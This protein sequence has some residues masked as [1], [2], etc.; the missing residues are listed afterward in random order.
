MRSDIIANSTTLIAKYISEIYVVHSSGIVKFA[1]NFGEKRY[2]EA[3]LIGSFV[4]AIESFM[5]VTS[6]KLNNDDIKL[7]DIGTSGSRWFIKKSDEVLLLSIVP[8]NSKF[9]DMESGFD[10]IGEISSELITNF[11]YMHQEDLDGWNFEVSDQFE[12]EVEETIRE[13]IE[14]Y[15]LE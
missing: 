2:F 4:T 10:L 1:K 13:K 7:T 5:E 3:Q 9:L 8:R 6:K 15:N 12:H 11:M 14:A